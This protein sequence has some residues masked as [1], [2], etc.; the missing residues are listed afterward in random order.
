MALLQCDS[1]SCNGYQHLGRGTEPRT[2]AL[3]T[4][5]EASGARTAARR[6]RSVIAAGTPK[7]GAGIMLLCGGE[8]CERGQHPGC[9]PSPLWTSAGSGLIFCEICAPQAAPAQP[10]LS[11]PT[12]LVLAGRLR[13]GASRP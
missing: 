12:Q 4:A 8:P 5:R 13:F 1:D 7:A 10:L 2:A 6:A 3:P 11:P 9:F